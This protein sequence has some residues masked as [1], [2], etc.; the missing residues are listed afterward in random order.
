MEA[1]MEAAPKLEGLA[2]NDPVYKQHL[3]PHGRP[4][5]GYYCPDPG[6][7]GQGL[8]EHKKQKP[9][10]KECMPAQCP[11]CNNGRIYSESN[12]MTHLFKTKVH[13]DVP[14]DKRHA[15]YWDAWEARRPRYNK[16]RAERGLI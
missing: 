14:W 3:C 13:D 5:N 11:L 1:T 8:C 12:I 15:L 16:W 2:P 6:C 4:G 9:T 10:C 7:S